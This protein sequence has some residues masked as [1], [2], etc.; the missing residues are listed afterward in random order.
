M[1]LEKRDYVVEC[2]YTGSES[3]EK[4]SDNKFIL[5]LLDVRLPDMNGHNLLR[6]LQSRNS[7]TSFIMITGYAS[8]E[9]AIEAVND[10]V[11][12]YI[13]KPLDVENVLLTVN[14]FM[15]QH[16]LWQEKSIVQGE[17]RR[18][19]ESLE[20]YASLLRHDVLNDLQ[21]VM[22]SCQVPCVL[23]LKYGVIIYII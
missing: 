19:Q 22:I 7:D 5:A 17:K 1:I 8:V 6:Q 10:N 4:A 11:I 12:A 13:T 15:K 18:Q 14:E 2:A 20:I 3:L 23:I 9:S 21:F 16:K